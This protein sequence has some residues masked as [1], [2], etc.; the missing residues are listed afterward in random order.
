MTFTF[1]VWRAF[2]DERKGMLFTRALPA[3]SFCHQLKKIP[4]QFLLLL[5]QQCGVS[6]GSA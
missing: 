2:S 1:L 3:L 4:G 5:A 6:I